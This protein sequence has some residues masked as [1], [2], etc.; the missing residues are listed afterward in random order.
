MQLRRRPHQGVPLMPTD[1]ASDLVPPGARSP[2]LG[3]RAC[4][5]SCRSWRGCA[6]TA[7]CRMYLPS[8][9]QE[10]PCPSCFSPC[11]ECGPYNAPAKGSTVEGG[12]R[13]LT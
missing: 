1:P 9:D 6:S 12:A 11:R 7:R 2:C 4:H 13:L 3:T 5:P 8:Y 10:L